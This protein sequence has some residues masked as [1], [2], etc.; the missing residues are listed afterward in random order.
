[1]NGEAEMRA[2]TSAFQGVGYRRVYACIGLMGDPPM[3]FYNCAYTSSV[4][5]A[6]VPS[7]HMNECSVTFIFGYCYDED[8]NTTTFYECDGQDFVAVC[9][10]S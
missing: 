5:E 4:Y 7:V 10:P 8:L 3:S 2:D 1:M 6:E 9:N